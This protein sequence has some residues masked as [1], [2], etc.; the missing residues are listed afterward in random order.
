MNALSTHVQPDGGDGPPPCKILGLANP[1][2]RGGKPMSLVKI[3]FVCVLAFVLSL[4][5]ARAAEPTPVTKW[6]VGVVNREALIIPPTKKTDGPV[7]VLFVFHGHGSS[8]AKM[9]D[10]GFQKHWPEAVIVCPQGLPTAVARDPEGKHSGWQKLPGDNGDR[11][12]K[13]VDAM[14]KTLRAKYRIDDAWVFATGHSNGGGFTSLLG[15]V[16]SKQFAAIALVA[17][18]VGGLLEADAAR[19][20]PVLYISGE[21]DEVIS[22]ADQRKIVEAIRKLNGC[23]ADGKPWAKGTN[24]V[25]TLYPSK[26]GAPVVSVMHPGTH[27]YPDNAPE[28]IVRF[29][30]EQASTKR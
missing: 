14:L 17:S 9:A 29:L 22:L 5:S 23:E 12:V 8:M 4:P 1:A 18:G 20:L 21:Q 30:K 16:R 27:K 13:F 11:D 2:R 15:A 10:L 26:D 7:P 25:G 6:T 24:F 3:T 28:L 19:R